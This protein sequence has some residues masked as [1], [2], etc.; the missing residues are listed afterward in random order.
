MTPECPSVLSTAVINIMTKSSLERKGFIWLTSYKPSPKKT[1]AGT[2]AKNMKAGTEAEPTEKYSLLAC[3]VFYD[4]RTTCPKMAWSTS[5]QALPQ[6]SSITKMTLNLVNLIG[7][8]LQ[9]RLPLPRCKIKDPDSQ[10][11]Q[12]SGGKQSQQRE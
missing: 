1:Q 4:P 5:G 7:A 9:L 3:L 2:Q 10:K 8:I 12:V 11:I 6:Q